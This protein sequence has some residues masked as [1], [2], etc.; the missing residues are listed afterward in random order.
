[1]R[2]GSAERVMG[3]NWLRRRPSLTGENNQD[4]REAMERPSI[5]RN[6]AYAN[7]KMFAGPSGLFQPMAGS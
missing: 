7:R 1:M 6:G 2:K 4:A 3:V 5:G